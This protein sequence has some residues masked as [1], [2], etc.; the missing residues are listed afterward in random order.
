MEVFVSIIVPNYNHAPFLEQRL[1]SVFNQT[2]Q[3]FEVILL[4]DASEDESLVLLNRY[5]NHP[6]VAHFLVN[7]TNSGSPFKQWQKGIELAK[8]DYI[9]IAESD[10]YCEL[11]FLEE[12]TK[13]LNSSI[14]I[15]YCSSTIVDSN[16]DFIKNNDWLNALNNRKWTES[17]IENGK[18]ELKKYLRFRNIMSNASSVIFKRSV[19][20]KVNIPKEYYFCG[21]WF[22]WCELAKKGN[23]S[24]VNQY[25][26]HFRKHA[27][28]TR[29][30]KSIAIEVRRFKEYFSIINTHSTYIFRFLNIRK[31]EWVVDDWM[32]KAKQFGFYKSLAAPLPLE[33]Y[34]FFCLKLFFSKFRKAFHII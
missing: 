14:T 6:K 22:L 28:T 13:T 5:A 15:A 26:N 18:D 21:D 4:D 17:Y 1:D 31:Y 25:L 24:Y 10:D 27:F 12:L 20:V 16:G 9:W 32:E 29:S 19:A 3:H 2:Y 11:T 7:E 8:G 23:I 33:L 34:L 30:T